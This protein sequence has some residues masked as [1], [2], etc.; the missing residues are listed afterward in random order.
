MEHLLLSNENIRAF[1]AYL[2]QNEKSAVT[3]EKYLR[4]VGAFF[5]FAGEGEIEIG[6]D[7]QTVMDYKA[8]LGK[9]YAVSSANSMLAALNVF[10]RFCGQGSLPSSDSRCKGKCSAS[11]KRS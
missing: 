3:V 1:G 7:K 11:S 8:Y 10:L 5:A 2:V 4:D 6:I 9:H